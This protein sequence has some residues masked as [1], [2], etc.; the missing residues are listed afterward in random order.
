MSNEVFAKIRELKKKEQFDNAWNCG[1][2]VFEGD[3]NNTYLRTALFWICYAAIKAVQE[4]VLSR[5]N[6]APNSNEQRIVNSWVSRI[7][8][9]KL[10]LPCEE[11]DFRFFNLFKGCGEHYQTYIQ[12]LIF[13]GPNLYQPKDKEPYQT[14]KGEYPSLLVRLVRQASKAWLQHHNEWQL[15]LEGILSLLQ[16]ALD[17]AHDKNKTWL[18]FDISKCLVSANRF[19][20]A[21]NAAF[22]VLRKKMSESWAWGAL[23]DTYFIEDT[24]AA[25]SCYSKAIVEAHEPPFCIP[26]YFGLAKL[27]SSAGNFKL[28]S[29][30]LSKLIEVYNANG[31]TL[32]PE[33]EELVQQPWFDASCIDEINFDVKIKEFAEQALQYATGKLEMVVGII[34]SHY[35]SGKGFSIY[36]DLGKK[37]S[38]RK[39]VFVGKGLPAV[40]SWVEG[41]TASDEGE[42]EVLEVYQ[43][44]DRS[45]EKVQF[46]EGE[47]IL[48]P[49]GFGFVNDAFVAPFLLNDFR[50]GERLKAIKIWDKDPKK[51]VPSWRVIKVTKS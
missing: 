50:D 15:N 29:A 25:I 31:W 17:N 11:L 26:L 10:D 42:V 9:L 5:Q 8:H 48:N 13:Y 37:L 3:P 2:S 34:D 7:G 24:K 28:A 16:Y 6:K 12:M 4:P 1:Y 40:G 33:H 35:R 20:E 19:E 45:S 39:G 30:S 27:F 36:I 43:I 21:R 23:A 14:E 38:V 49:K 41:K 46:I 18:Q 32:K 22:S 47:L 51:G 44:D